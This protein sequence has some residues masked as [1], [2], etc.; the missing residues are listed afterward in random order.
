M[1][2]KRVRRKE[3]PLLLDLDTV[4]TIYVKSPEQG[5][6][7]CALGLEKVCQNEIERIGLEAVGREPG[8]VRFSLGPLEESGAP[9]SCAPISACAAPSASS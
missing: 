7:L 8:R 3:T 4:H 6:A 1:S 2:V 5:W 9:A